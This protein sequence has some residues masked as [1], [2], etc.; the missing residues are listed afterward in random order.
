MSTRHTRNSPDQV[1]EWLRSEPDLDELVAAYPRHWEHVQADIDRIV[2]GG[3]P[4][5]VK[6]YLAQVAN[7]APTLR[8]RAKP[9][10]DLI[11]D[12]IRRQMTLQTL[13]QALLAAANGGREG[14]ARLGL[15]TGFVAQKLLFRRDLERKPASALLTRMAWPLLRQRRLL[16]PLVQPKGIYCFYTAAL[17]GRLAWMIGPRRCLEIAAGDGT[18]AR[19]LAVRGVSITATDDHSWQ[20][21]V[22][23]PGDVQREDARTALRRHQPEVVVCSWPPPGNTFERWV[24]ETPSVDLYVVIGSRQEHSAGDWDAYRGQESFAM[25]VDPRLSRL[26]LPPEIDPAVLVFRRHG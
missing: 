24:F 5:T 17:I 12:E 7:P 2:A 20:S 21:R 8:G 10:R 11:A 13:Q 15:V 1:L 22:T 26:V 14:R 4:E 25:V 19:F 23:Y 6:A 18:L 3:D 16:M 9:R